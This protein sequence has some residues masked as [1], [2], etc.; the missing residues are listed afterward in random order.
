MFL[1]FGMK[2]GSPQPDSTRQAVSGQCPV[3]GQSGMLQPMKARRFISLFF[4]PLIP[5]G[6]Q[7]AV[8]CPNCGSL[9]NA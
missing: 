3:C 4:V 9:L 1:I 6:A 5:V 7:N 8:Q 2:Q